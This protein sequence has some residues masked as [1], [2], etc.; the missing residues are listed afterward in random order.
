M[1][2]LVNPTNADATT[3]ETKEMQRAA[4]VLGLRLLTLDATTPQ[5]IE[6]AFATAFPA[7]AGALVVGGDSFFYANRD[8]VIGLAARFSVPAVYSEP[9]FYTAAGGLMGYGA[10]LSDALRIAGLYVGRI[11]KGEKPADLPVQQSTRIEM[12]LNLK[13]AK[14]LGLTVPQSILLRAD[15]VIE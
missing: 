1:A 11:L 8:Q 9:H 13:T 10:S 2:L 15:E 3:A 5:E 4:G 12:V 7:Q 14:A 6:T